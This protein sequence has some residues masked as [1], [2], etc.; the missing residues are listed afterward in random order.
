MDVKLCNCCATEGRE[1]VM[2]IVIGK[3]EMGTWVDCG[4]CG[5]T[6]LIPLRPTDK[7]VTID[8]QVDG[9]NVKGKRNESN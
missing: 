9:V 1:S 3:N 5:S 4:V 2:D 7:D 8:W 6:G